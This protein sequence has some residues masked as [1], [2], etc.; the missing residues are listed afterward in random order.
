MTTYKSEKKLEYG[1]IVDPAINLLPNHLEMAIKHVYEAI[2]M[3]VTKEAIREPECA[4]YGACSLEIEGKDIVFREAKTTPVKIGQFVTIWKRPIDEIIPFD[5]TD[6]VDFIVIGVSDSQNQG[7]FVFD[8]R[9][10]IEKGIMSHNGKK[11]KTAFRVYPPWTKP[12][13]KQAVKTQQ[14]QLRY[15]FPFGSNVA[16]D[17]ESIRKLFNP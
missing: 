7:Q 2:G 10:L 5:S 12:V 9:I 17:Q 16:I 11:G 4:E 8:K 14:W 3:T 6:N 15:F 1:Q 13:V